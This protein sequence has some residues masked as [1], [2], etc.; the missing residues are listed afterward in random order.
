MALQQYTYSAKPQ[1]IQHDWIIIDAEDL[2]L[3]RLSAIVAIRLR[4]KHK[5]N[6]TPHVDCGDNIIIIN[7]EKVVLTGNKRFQKTYYW[8]TGYPGGIK[9]RKADKILDGRFPDRV[10]RKAVERMIPRGPLGRQVMRQLYIYAGSNHPHEAQ[11]P[12]SLDVKS[13]NRKNS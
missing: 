9:E 1:E 11:S 6:Y 7:C 3:G 12:Q 13:M 10:I 5:V 2:V 8:H 4:G